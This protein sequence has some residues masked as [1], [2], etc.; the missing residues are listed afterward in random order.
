MKTLL[1]F[2][3]D[4]Q[5]ALQHAIAKSDYGTP[6]QAVAWLA[7]FSHPNTV[8]QTGGKNIFNVVRGKTSERGYFDSDSTPS[9]MFDDNTSAILT[10]VWG[11]SLPNRGRDLQYN[12]LVAKQSEIS[13]NRS[14][15]T[16]LANI[17]V[18]PAF[19]SKLSDGKA[20]SIRKMLIA[21]A[22]DLYSK[23][24]SEDPEIFL[25]EQV[26]RPSF[27][28]KIKWPE[29]L[30]AVSDVRASFSD[31]MSRNKSKVAVRSVES[32][33]WHFSDNLPDASFKKN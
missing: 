30:P 16:N 10:F 22:Y 2:S 24:L 6:E 13:K 4:G 32:L 23:I 26:D 28:S 7:L 20:S 18:L 17:V 8:R 31:R 5:K 12:H 14:T 11:N 25:G 1:Q 33:G 27:Y 29:T 9:I 15:Y 21:R 3:L 19:L